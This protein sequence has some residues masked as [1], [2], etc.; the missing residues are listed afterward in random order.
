MNYLTSRG[1]LAAV[2]LLQ[3]VPKCQDP[4]STFGRGAK[5]ANMDVLG[6]KMGEKP[7]KNHEKT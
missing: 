3:A 2:E 6:P 7:L 5:P 4:Q 1:H